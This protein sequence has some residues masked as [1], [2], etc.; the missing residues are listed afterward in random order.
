[1]DDPRSTTNLTD[2]DLIRRV[3]EG[4]T[5]AL[6]LL[7]DRSA[8]FVYANAFRMLH[9]RSRAQDLVSQVY[10]SFWQ[11]QSSYPGAWRRH[12]AGYQEERSALTSWLLTLTHSLAIRSFPD[13]FH[14]PES[15]FADDLDVPRDVRK[16]EVRQATLRVLVA[17]AMDWLPASQR[18]VFELRAVQ[19]LNAQDPLK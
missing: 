9:D 10:F 8:W 7:Y 17:E 2:A 11:W 18:H 12:P 16:E 13:L 3:A 5:G 6:E 19:G 14:I 15:R 4:E 1:M